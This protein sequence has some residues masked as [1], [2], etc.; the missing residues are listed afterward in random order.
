MTIEES[1]L[2]GGGCGGGFTHKSG[3]E[4]GTAGSGVGAASSPRP[5][6]EALQPGARLQLV[7]LPVGMYETPRTCLGSSQEGLDCVKAPKPAP[8]EPPAKYLPMWLHTTR[9]Y[10]C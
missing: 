5:P 4:A 6:A 3:G 10:P 2:G 1:G 9:H 8:P 7:T